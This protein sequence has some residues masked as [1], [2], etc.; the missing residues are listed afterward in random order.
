M[1][2][3]QTAEFSTTKPRSQQKDAQTN[4]LQLAYGLNELEE[5]SAQKEFLHEHDGHGAAP[6]EVLGDKLGF[7][8]SVSRKKTPKPVTLYGGFR[9]RC[10]GESSWC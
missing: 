9:S 10:Q 1:R 8:P 6:R 3:C 5:L 2:Q 4:L 7:A